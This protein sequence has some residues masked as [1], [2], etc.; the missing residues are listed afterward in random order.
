MR[1]IVGLGVTSADG[2][3]HKEGGEQGKRK[4]SSGTGE[5]PTRGTREGRDRLASDEAAQPARAE[6]PDKKKQRV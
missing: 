2:A 5:S 4:L 6:T 1:S 3:R